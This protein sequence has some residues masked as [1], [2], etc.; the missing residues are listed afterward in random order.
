MDQNAHHSHPKDNL[1][2]NGYID[3]RIFIFYLLIFFFV[4]LGIEPR[5]SYKLGEGIIKQQGKKMN[6]SAQNS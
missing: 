3:S 1:Q 2:Q 6:R 4:V 5:V